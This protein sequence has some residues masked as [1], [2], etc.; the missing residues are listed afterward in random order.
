VNISVRLRFYAIIICSD[1]DRLPPAFAGL[2]IILHLSWGSR[3]R[4][5]AVTCFAGFLR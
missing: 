2:D 1:I 3:P 5:Y 4:L